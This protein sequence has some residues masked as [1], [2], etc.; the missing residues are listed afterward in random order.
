MSLSLDQA[1]SHGDLVIETRCCARVVRR[2]S[3]DGQ[4]M[5]TGAPSKLPLLEA[6]IQHSIA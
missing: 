5:S 3:G 6:N 2:K 1:G 4:T